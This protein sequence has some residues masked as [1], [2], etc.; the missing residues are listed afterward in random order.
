MM[1]FL[2]VFFTLVGDVGVL[3]V[4][5]LYWNER[6][7]HEG[8]EHKAF[9]LQLAVII[10]AAALCI[11]VIPITLGYHLGVQSERSQVDSGNFGAYP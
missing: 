5:W 9:F 3:T 4:G 8:K 7:E 2:V 10:M 11:H 6:R 1:W